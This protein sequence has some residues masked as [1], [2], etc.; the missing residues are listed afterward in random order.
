MATSASVPIEC[1]PAAIEASLARCRTLATF[2][3]LRETASTQDAARAASAPVGS[4]VI[5]WRQ[6]GGRGRLGRAWA[7]TGTDGVAMTLALPPAPPERLAM[8]SAVATA[9]ALAT[10]TG[11]QPTAAPAQGA[12][13][14]PA[15]AAPA[16]LAPSIGI[17]WPNDIML[18]GRKLAGILVEQTE[19]RALV[20]IGANTSQREF[21][22]PIASRAI[23]LAQA[24]LAVDRLAVVCNLIESMD[25][26]L[27]RSTADIHA[28]YMRRDCLSGSQAAFLTPSGQVQG[29]VI[30]VDPLQGLRV[31]TDAG[32]QFLAAATTSVVL[33][34]P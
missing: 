20:G 34:P 13:A 33:A 1:W 12:P 31:A 28:E 32:E 2:T 18:N 22:A 5:A 6:T 29:R 19:G 23:S 27:D 3:L 26:W 21:P 14:A 9:C 25:A 4:V 8:L 11:A 24:G 30:S 17:K 15:S 16:A 7:D 10:S